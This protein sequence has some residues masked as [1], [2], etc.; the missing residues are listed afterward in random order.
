MS[1][2][3][4]RG[5][6]MARFLGGRTNGQVLDPACWEESRGVM[7]L[8][9]FHESSL[10]T[11]HLVSVETGISWVSGSILCYWGPGSLLP[12]AKQFSDF[13]RVSASLITPPAGPPRGGQGQGGA[14][15]IV[16]WLP[17][18]GDWPPPA[19]PGSQEAA[20]ALCPGLGR[21]L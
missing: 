17:L 7:R 18:G 6:W 4:G 10:E 21:T 19:S 1:G 14:Q 8:R 20:I 11:R 3:E 12:K 2:M 5:G 16:S 15:P 9:G 13:L